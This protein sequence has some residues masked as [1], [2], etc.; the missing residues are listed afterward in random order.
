MGIRI[1]SKLIE[2]QT[3]DNVPRGARRVV[4]IAGVVVAAMLVWVLFVTLWL[5]RNQE[6]VVFQPPAADIVAPAPAKRVEFKASDNHQLY[7]YLVEP[8][9]LKVAGSP[10]APARDESRVPGQDLSSSAAKEP[11]TV[12]IAFHGNAD[13]AAWLVPWAR[14]LADRAGVSVLLP[15]YRGYAAIPGNPSYEAAAADARGALD[16]TRTAFRP[17]RMVLFGHSLGSAVATDVADVMR[18]DAPAALVLQSPFTSAREMATRVL[19]PPIP[20]LW[21]RISRVHYDTRAIVARLG[22]PVWVAHGVRDVVVPVRMGREVFSAARHPAELLIVDG[23]GHNDVAEAGGDRYW[24]WL[25]A[26][27]SGEARAAA[28][29]ESRVTGY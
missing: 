22:C 21:R 7:G 19:L 26:A 29:I 28:G 14:E 20:W 2:G 16:F 5:W 11:R 10:R 3:M 17:S 24:Q 18:P 23:A 6:R 15:E 1:V 27:V 9:P 25:T 4:T 12:V 13:L 8:S